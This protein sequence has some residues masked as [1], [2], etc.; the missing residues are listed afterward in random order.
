MFCITIGMLRLFERLDEVVMVAWPR[1]E[2]CVE[3]E[4]HA[5]IETSN[6]RWIAE[7]SK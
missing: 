2:K 6:S 7:R 3:D 4:M 5:R 1:V